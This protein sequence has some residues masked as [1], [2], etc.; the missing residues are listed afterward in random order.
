MSYPVLRWAGSRIAPALSTLVRLW[1]ATWRLELRGA[2][3]P[4]GERD[5]GFLYCFPHGCMFELAA[6]HADRGVGV[7]AS[8][9]PDGRL[10]E[11]VVGPLG[12][13]PF[14]G[15]RREGALRGARGLVRHAASGRDLGMAG[16]AQTGPLP[17]GALRLARL[18]GHAIVPVVAVAR[19]RWRAKSWD[20]FEIPAPGARVLIGYGRPIQVPADADETALIR[21]LESVLHRLREDLETEL[22]GMSSGHDTETSPDG[23]ALQ[24]A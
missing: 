24:G 21:H 16:D 12:Y 3:Q 13:V 4:A 8:P 15:S 18:T 17:R 22:A 20:G 19:P 9:H 23:R 6:A 11:R 7:L 5:H 10:A 2:L 14:R 1:S